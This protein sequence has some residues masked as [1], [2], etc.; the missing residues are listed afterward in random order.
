M[1]VLGRERLSI[2]ALVGCV[3]GGVDQ[4]LGARVPACLAL[5]WENSMGHLCPLRPHLFLHAP[6]PASTPGS[7][8]PTPGRV[9]ERLRP[10]LAPLAL[11]PQRHPA[12]SVFCAETRRWG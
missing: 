5:T 10:P 4:E 3:S 1:V 11:H 12:A 8:S 7:Q 2:P 6:C 9:P